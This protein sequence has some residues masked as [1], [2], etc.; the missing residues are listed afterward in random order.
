MAMGQLA[1]SDLQNIYTYLQ[2]G[3]KY[4]I[5]YIVSKCTQQD[6]IHGKKTLSVCVSG[7]RG[8]TRVSFVFR[9]ILFPTC[10]K[11]FSFSIISTT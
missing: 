7:G 1:K 10:L 11:F 4:I 8:D 2:S 6:P 9:L 3:P 5:N